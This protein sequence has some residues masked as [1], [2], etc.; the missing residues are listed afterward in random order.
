MGIKLVS[1]PP[2]NEQAESDG[3]DDGLGESRSSALRAAVITISLGTKHHERR[4]YGS[5]NLKLEA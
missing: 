2:E 3:D 5:R 1:G 4:R